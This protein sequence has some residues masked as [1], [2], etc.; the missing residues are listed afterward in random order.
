ML[1]GVF[2]AGPLRKPVWTFGFDRR[3]PVTAELLEKARTATAERAVMASTPAAVKAFMLKLLELLHLLDTGAF[4]KNRSGVARRVRRL[5]KKRK[6]SF[7]GLPA[8]VYDR[9]ALHAQAAWA[10]QLLG[11]WRGALAVIDEVG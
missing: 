7:A 11:V 8:G 9:G 10:V 1:R 4:P 6:S 3:T 5:L 2:G